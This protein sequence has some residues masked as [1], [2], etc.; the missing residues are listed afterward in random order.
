MPIISKSKNNKTTEMLSRQ[1]LVINMDIS[2]FQ[3]AKNATDFKIKCCWS[4]SVLRKK[5][6]NQNKF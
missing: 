1:L 3:E 4:D 6:V 2:W 5:Q